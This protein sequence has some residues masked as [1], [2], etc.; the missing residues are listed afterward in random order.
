MLALYPDVEIVGEAEDAIEGVQLVRE[1]RPDMVFLDVEMPGG[2]GFSL[3]ESMRVNPA[4]FV[5]FVSA[6]AEHAVRAFDAD[7]VDYLLKPFDDKRLGR[8]VARARDAA[9]GWEVPRLASEVRTLLDT[10]KGSGTP[11]DVHPA[12]E[13]QPDP[14]LRRIAVTVGARTVFVRT[15][16]LDWI[17]A[18]DNYV[19]LHAGARHF[20]VRTTLSSLEQQLDPD[21]FVRVHRSAILRI[22]RV[23]EVRTRSNGDTRAL[24]A[25]DAEVAI[26]AR[27]RGRLRGS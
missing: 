26:S 19:R 9:S 7:A 11:A 17:E 14:Y 2:D 27:Y 3:L 12:R 21:A 8:S 6:H 23:E 5:V 4:P 20:V 15:D 16:E 18:S 1:L 25:N 13:A 10:L 24:L 22:D